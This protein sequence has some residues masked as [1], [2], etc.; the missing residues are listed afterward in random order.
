MKAKIRKS[1]FQRVLENESGVTILVLVIT[2]IVLVIISAITINVLF[3]ENGLI[4][5]S[6]N[7]IGMADQEV[8]EDQ[9]KLNDVAYEHN[10]LI[11]E[12]ARVESR[13]NAGDYVYY[14]DRTGVTR[15]CAV[16]YD[17]SSEYG[18][19]IISMETVEEAQITYDAA[20]SMLNARAAEYN[21]IVY[22]ESARCV[23]SVPDNPNYEEVGPFASTYLSKYNYQ[24][25][26]EDEN[27]KED[28]EQMTNLGIL[29]A[30]DVDGLR[31]YYWLASRHI[32]DGYG[33]WNYV[34]DIFSVDRAHAIG[35]A[36]FRVRTTV[37][38]G[39]L[40]NEA[41][42]FTVRNDSTTD[43]TN[44]DE[45]ITKSYGL[46]PVFKLK[47]EVIVTGGSGTEEDPYT[48]GI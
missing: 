39:Y 32:I 35:S 26:D 28:Y 30:H 12:D 10:K 29:D 43:F 37:D 31:T 44:S 47:D 22:S 5:R 1:N 19:E 18:V 38:T 42:F 48:L 4:Q 46:R 14:E 45:T 34:G 40:N 2:V 15:L 7:S 23:G 33:S 9:A 36:S 21:N 3:D 17:S 20:I 6:R 16:L 13:L 27:Y 11:R 24:F 25:K 41:I 8:Q